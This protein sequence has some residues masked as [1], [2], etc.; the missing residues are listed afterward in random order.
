M[1]FF[2]S[3]LVVFVLVGTVLFTPLT[4][5]YFFSDDFIWLA[6]AKRDSLE[7]IPS[8][9]YNSNGFFYRPL[10]KIYFWNAW[11]WFGLDATGYH[12]ANILL[13]TGVSVAVYFFILKLVAPLQFIKSLNKKQ[14]LAISTSFLFFVHPVHLENI[15]WPSAITELLPS[16]F[17]LLGLLLFCSFRLQKNNLSG[18]T[19]FFIFISFLLA[20]FG[21]EFSVIFPVLVVLTD[22]YF[23]YFDQKH[24]ITLHGVFALLKSRTAFYIGLVL[25]DIFYL[26]VRSYAGS[27][28][29][30]GD[31]SYNLI[32]LP[33]NVVGNL[34][35]YLSIGILG[36]QSI[37]T[38]QWLRESLRSYF[39]Y[40]LL[41]LAG[42]AA[43][44]GFIA[45]TYFLKHFR[46]SE[47][48]VVLFYSSLFFVVCLAPFLGL[49]SIAERYIYL[50]L[51]FLMLGISCLCLFISEYVSH[52]YEYGKS[53][54]YGLFVFIL[55]S[56]SMYYGYSMLRDQEN[57]DFAS[58]YVLSAVNDIE[59]NCP[60]YSEGEALRKKSP[61]NRIGR[62]WVFQV[63]YEQAAN[64]VCEKNLRMFLY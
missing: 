16:F 27:H 23:S 20:L 17:I 39:L 3:L 47:K 14:L 35:G 45:Y 54:M 50:P 15:I 36:T 11:R 5:L 4:Q 33:V 8:Y 59:E 21:H 34:F 28:W 19:G 64:L 31:Y 56:I 10:T 60:I 30:G 46:L 44:A 41:G 6:D 40:F 9:F 7:Q 18:I 26:I 24:R 2:I 22:L 25:V 1:K 38:Y 12:V 57:W 51:L 48:I 62:A 37:D 29:S 58:R 55:L 53:T 49:G 43:G 32:K 52:F 63:G 61:P 13:H 42:L